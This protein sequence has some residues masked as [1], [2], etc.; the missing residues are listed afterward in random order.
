MIISGGVNIYPAEI[1]AVLYAHPNVLDAA[2]FGIPD[3][4]WGESVYAIVQPKANEAIDLEDL[5]AFVE[6][7]L[8]RYKRPRAYEVRDVLPRTDSGKLLKRVLRYEFWA[9]HGRSL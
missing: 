7:R 4:E 8:A 5:A 9:E 3:D 2:V 1:E 6:D